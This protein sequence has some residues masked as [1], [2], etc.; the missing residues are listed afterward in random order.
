MPPH[1]PTRFF[2]FRT[3][4]DLKDLNPGFNPSGTNDLVPAPNT[5]GGESKCP[6]APLQESQEQPILKT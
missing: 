4:K 3:E 1:S 5:K 2:L 6:P